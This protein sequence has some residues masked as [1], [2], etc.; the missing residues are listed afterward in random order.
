MQTGRVSDISDADQSADERIVEIATVAAI[1]LLMTYLLM[2]VVTRLLA[3][4][5]FTDEISS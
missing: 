3:A 4:W 5:L 1:V 2:P